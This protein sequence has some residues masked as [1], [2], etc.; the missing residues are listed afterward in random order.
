MIAPQTLGFDPFFRPFRAPFS[1][2]PPV[3]SFRVFRVFRRPP[4]VSCFLCVG[5]PWPL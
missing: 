1:L 3:K 2:F 4:S 5:A